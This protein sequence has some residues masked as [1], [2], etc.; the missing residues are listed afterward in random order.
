MVYAYMHKLFRI[1]SYAV[2]FLQR[3]IREA[4]SV[5]QETGSDLMKSAEEL[6]MARTVQKNIL[7]TIE[8]LNLCIP[9]GFAVTAHYMKYIY[10]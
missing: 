5:I 3:K 9:G 8:T 7:S 4:D 6:M 1:A 2:L 10:L